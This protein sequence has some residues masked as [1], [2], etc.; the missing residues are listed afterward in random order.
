M[1]YRPADKETGELFTTEEHQISLPARG[2]EYV[3]EVRAHSEGGDG[4]VAAVRISGNLGNH[5]TALPEQGYI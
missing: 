1:L 4:A 2:G 5:F 3:V